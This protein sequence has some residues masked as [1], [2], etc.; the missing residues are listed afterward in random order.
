MVGGRVAGGAELRPMS[1]SR[2]TSA[3][4]VLDYDDQPSGV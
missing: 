1:S 2:S 3:A 4:G